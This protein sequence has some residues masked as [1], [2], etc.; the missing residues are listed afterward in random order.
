MDYLV[1][2]FPSLKKLETIGDAFVVVGIADKIN[3]ENDDKKRSFNEMVEFALL[4]KEMAKIVPMDTDNNV[5]LRIGAHCGNLVGGLAGYLN[6]RFNLF[7]DAMNCCAR[8]EATGEVDKIHISTD[9]AD[10]IRYYSVDN[11]NLI[12]REPIEIKGKGLMQTW[13]L[14]SFDMNVLKEKHQNSIEIATKMSIMGTEDSMY[15][16]F[17]RLNKGKSLKILLEE[18]FLAPNAASDKLNGTDIV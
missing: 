14:E 12:R 18:L 6:P 15:L 1:S 7:G 2:G 4:V 9:F 17:Y 10:K 13:F 5:R 16:P 8:M 3:E 11:I